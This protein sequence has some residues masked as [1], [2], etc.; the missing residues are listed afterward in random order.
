MDSVCFTG[1]LIIKTVRVERILTHDTPISL[2]APNDAQACMSPFWVAL[3]AER[4][5]KGH[6][7]LFPGSKGWGR[8]VLLGSR[9]PGSPGSESE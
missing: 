5:E 3:S 1:R 2:P 4:G 9:W 8:A 7:F 6:Q